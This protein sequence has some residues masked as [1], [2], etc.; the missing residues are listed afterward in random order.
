MAHPNDF[1]VIYHHFPLD[2]HA[3][4]LPLAVASECAADQGR[5]EAF[6]DSTFSMVRRRVEPTPASVATTI[7][8]QDSLRYLHCLADSARAT[9]VT[10]D[11]DNGTTIGVTGTPA[12]IVEGKLLKQLFDSTLLKTYLV[13]AMKRAGKNLAPASAPAGS[14]NE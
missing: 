6:F 2:Y 12:V 10:N 11:R 1:A 9:A 14:Q 8:I 5:F 4:A 3:N 13:Q 7:G